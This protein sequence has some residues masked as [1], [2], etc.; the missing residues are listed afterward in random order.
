MAE[1]SDVTVYSQEMLVA[2]CHGLLCIQSTHSYLFHPIFFSVPIQAVLLRT[3]KVF[4]LF[5]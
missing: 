1:G 4:H 3:N 2:R 5:Y